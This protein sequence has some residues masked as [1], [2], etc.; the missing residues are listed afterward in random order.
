MIFTSECLTENNCLLFNFQPEKSSENY[1]FLSKLR[2]IIN[3]EKPQKTLLLAY[4]TAISQFTTS[5]RIQN[6][7][8]ENQHGKC[9]ENATENHQKSV[10][11][12]RRLTWF[13]PCQKHANFDSFFSS[14][15]TR[16]PSKTPKKRGSNIDLEI[17]TIFY[18]FFIDFGALLGPLGASLGTIFPPKCCGCAGVMRFWTRFGDF[19]IAFPP[20]G[21]FGTTLGT[22]LASFFTNLG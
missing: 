17:D 22:I 19:C 8:F 7:A 5:A 20:Y 15:S 2:K 10:E 1:V 3:F 18:R 12:L 9:I 6:Q 14:K 13:R 16:N 11:K 4:K 21:A